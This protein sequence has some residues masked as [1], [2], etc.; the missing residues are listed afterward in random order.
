MDAIPADL[1]ELVFSKSAVNP[2]RLLAYGFVKK[3]DGYHLSVPFH[4]GEFTAE[5]KVCSDGNVN[6][7]VIETEMEEEYL[8]LRVASQT[9]AFVSQIRKEYYDLLCD[10]RDHAF[11][12]QLFAGAQAN[13]LAEVIAETFSDAWDRPFS[14][15][16]DAVVFRT[17]GNQKWYAL[18]MRMKKRKVSGT[19]EDGECE[20]LNLRTDEAE[21]EKLICEAGIYPAWHMNKKTWISVMLDDTLCDDRIFALIRKSRDLIAGNSLAKA[22]NEWIIPSNPKIYDIHRH[23]RLNQTA[24]WKQNIRASVGDIVYIYSGA[25]E[26]AIRYK[27]EV[28]AADLPSSGVSGNGKQVKRMR[29]KVLKTYPPELLTMKV[30]RTFGVRSMQG[31]KRVPV[32]LK[33]V[34]DSLAEI[35]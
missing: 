26:S 34:I 23:F 14:R 3:E 27:T 22:A 21:H 8:P 33:K 32:E 19:E 24:E 10:I 11:D 31:S 5:I 35:E 2:A 30:L 15:L 13:R 28:V 25:P 12:D 4:N 17:P 7:T 1:E 9:S 18:V 20:V 6:G 29:L 16:K